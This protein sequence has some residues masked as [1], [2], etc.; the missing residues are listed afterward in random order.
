MKQAD[1]FKH[2]ENPAAQLS[3][4]VALPDEI[5]TARDSWFDA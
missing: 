1:T 5:K 4:P 2:N 3:K